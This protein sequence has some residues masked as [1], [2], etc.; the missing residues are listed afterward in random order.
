[1][2]KTLSSIAGAL[3][4]LFLCPGMDG[5]PQRA[6]DGGVAMSR[7]G[8]YATKSQGWRCGDVHGWTVCHKELGMAVF[9][10]VEYL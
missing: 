5:M 2:S 9:S 8:R 1:M 7:D 3:H 10:Q 6:K 4:R